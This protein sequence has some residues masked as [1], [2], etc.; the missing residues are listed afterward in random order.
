MLER[1]EFR[2][3]PADYIWFFIFGCSNFLLWAYVLGLQFLSH[4]ISTMMLY[5]WARK[6]PNIPFSFFNVINFRCCFLPI[7]FLLLVL[8]SGYD[9][10]MEILGNVVGHIYYYLTDVVPLIPETQDLKL[11]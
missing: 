7:F 8:L 1:N 10:T 4:C 3:K 6:N 5:I 2:N 11:L 9:P